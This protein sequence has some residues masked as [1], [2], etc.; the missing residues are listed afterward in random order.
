M[1]S[2]PLQQV[3][4]HPL[5]EHAVADRQHVVAAR[6]VERASLRQQV[7]EIDR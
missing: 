7:C 4:Q 5:F 1:L 2:G 6:D 3:V